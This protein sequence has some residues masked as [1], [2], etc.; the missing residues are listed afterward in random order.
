MPGVW[1]AHRG[2]WRCS[3]RS[4]ADGSARWAVDGSAREE[5]LVDGRASASDSNQPGGRTCGR[6]A[7]TLAFGRDH[8]CRS[9]GEA[10]WGLSGVPHPN[11]ADNSARDPSGGQGLDAAAGSRE[12][13]TRIRS[14]QYRPETA[15]PRSRRRREGR[16]E[17][18]N[19]VAASEAI[20][21]HV[22]NVHGATAEARCG[23]REEGIFQSTSNKRHSADT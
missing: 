16:S 9:I 22:E 8:E 23:P 17:F 13:S 18:G 11:S 7:S 3:S 4:S 5:P 20:R 12:G 1:N 15:R 19:E 14:R 6:A 21:V 2:S 10:D